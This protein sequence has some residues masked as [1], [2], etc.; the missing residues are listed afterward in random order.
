LKKYGIT[1]EE[2]ERFDVQYDHK[3]ELLCFP[4][5][6]EDGR[7]TGYVCRNFG[8]TRLQRK[9]LF[10]GSRRL[11]PIIDSPESD[12]NTGVFVEDMISAIKVGR[13]YTALPV[14]SANIDAKALKWASERFKWVGVWLDRDMH[15]KVSRI[16]FKGRCMGGA[17][18]FPVYTKK[19]PKAYSDSEIENIFEE[20]RNFSL[21]TLSN[22]I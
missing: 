2:I 16:A 7:I 10:Y 3:R 5:K 20:A 1:D 11:P 18:F 21:Q 17:N 15:G 19:D 6:K 8:P 14:L 13:S 9:Y 12:K 22:N 4:L